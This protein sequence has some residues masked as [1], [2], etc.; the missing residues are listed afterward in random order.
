MVPQFV[1]GR[2]ELLAFGTFQR[3]IGV[4]QHVGFEIGPL[5][6]G[7]GADGAFVGRFFHVEDLVH[8]QRSG[9]AESF[10][11]LGAFEWFFF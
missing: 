7:F 2:E 5:V 10:T 1:I 9:L 8:R 6:E 4:S 11:A 3:S